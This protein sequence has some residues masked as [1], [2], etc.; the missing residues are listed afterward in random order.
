[1][2]DG[3][4]ERSPDSFLDRRQEL[5][6][7][8]MNFS[9]LEFWIFFFFLGDVMEATRRGETAWIFTLEIN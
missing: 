4:P 7:I 1:M 9:L 3:A 2:L 5:C 8:M 6:W